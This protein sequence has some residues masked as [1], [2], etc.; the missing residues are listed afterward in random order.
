MKN[1]K[2]K[3]ERLKVQK[4]C[5]GFTLHRSPWQKSWTSSVQRNSA[6]FT[7]IELVLVIGIMAIMSTVGFNAF[8]Q[9]RKQ[10]AFNSAVANVV[11]DLYLIRDRAQS[12]V[13]FNRADQ[14]AC[15]PNDTRDKNSNVLRAWELDVCRIGGLPTDG[16][17][18]HP[19]QATYLCEPYNIDYVLTAVC[20]DQ[21]GVNQGD[22]IH[23]QLRK[24]FSINDVQFIE[25]STN[26]IGFRIYPP[27]GIILGDYNDGNK[28][29]IA[30]YGY[31]RTITVNDDQS[32]TVTNP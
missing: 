22:D 23:S 16:A 9:Y 14:L 11:N 24:K 25:P 13:A 3:S 27:G 7:I 6:G 1:L 31:Q 30:G 29:I 15:D 2:A 8:T 4:N 5:K 28:L 32:I 17:P 26:W 19:H 12:K 18:G 10:Q 21:A 20:Q